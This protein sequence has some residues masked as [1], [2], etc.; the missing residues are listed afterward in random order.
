MS[1]L[2][3]KEFVERANTVLLLGV[4]WGGLAA[5][6]IGALAYDI[7]HSLPRCFHAPLSSLNLPNFLSV[8]RTFH[9]TV[10][11]RTRGR[12][13]PT[14]CELAH[15]WVG[16]YIDPRSEIFAIVTSG[17]LP[18]RWIR[19]TPVSCSARWHNRFASIGF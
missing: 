3:D 16:G 18:C 1:H 14:F 13:H 11:R 10:L 15:P 12:V 17:R 9:L 7:A 2:V 6:V 4:L 5:C 8:G 19:A